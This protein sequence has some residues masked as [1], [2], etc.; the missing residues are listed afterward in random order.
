MKPK[1]R[2]DESEAEIVQ[3]ITEQAEQR[4]QDHDRL[5]D[6]VTDLDIQVEW[7]TDEFDSETT[8]YRLDSMALVCLY[9]FARG[10]SFTDVVD[11]LATTGEES[12]FGLPTVPTQQSFHY[13]W[14]NRFDST[15]RSVIRKAAL[16][17]RFAHEFH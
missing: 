4:S 11:F 17:V 14:R 6:L 3:R 10:M 2:S 5:V 7:F 15:D 12:Q 8:R 13:A 16:R 1:I 9:K